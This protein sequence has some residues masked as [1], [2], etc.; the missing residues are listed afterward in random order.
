[1]SRGRPIQ[2]PGLVHG[3]EGGELAK[4]QLAIMLE[5]LSGDC[6]I[7]AACAELGIGKS[8]FFELRHRVLQAALEDLTPRP[9]GRP[10]KEVTPEEARIAELEKEITRLK[11]QLETAWVREEL[12][13]AM[14]Q[15]FQPALQRQE[16]KKEAARQASQRGMKARKGDT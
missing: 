1:M 9:M 4:R 12:L 15:V 11:L 3:L 7:A 2:G 13:L 5:T 16:K 6:D 14:P 8:A 10:P